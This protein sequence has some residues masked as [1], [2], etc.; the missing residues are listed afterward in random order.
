MALQEF[1]RTSKR[2]RVASN[3]PFITIGADYIHFNKKF[4]DKYIDNKLYVCL[5]YDKSSGDLGFKFESKDVANSFKISVY[6]DTAG[7]TIH[8]VGAGKFIKE[9]NI[10]KSTRAKFNVK[11]GIVV[12]RKET[13]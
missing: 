5:L 13:I 9:N 7:Y 3:V 4:F 2:G 1:V 12:A 8:R 6:T 10:E 11:N